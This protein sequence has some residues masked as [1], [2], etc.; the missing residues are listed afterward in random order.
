M[1]HRTMPQIKIDMDLLSVALDDH[2]GYSSYFLDKITGRTLFISED[3]M[4]DDGGKIQKRIEDDPERYLA[5]EPVSSHESFRIME[6]FVDTLPAGEAKLILSKAL[7]WKKPFNNFRDALYDYP[8]IR[9][10]WFEFHGKA[11]RELASEWLKAEGIDA[12]LAG[13]ATNGGDVL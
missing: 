10:Q 8:D 5:I 12:D 2:S 9:K 13:R 11:L 7:S 6:E 3:L 4:N 1:H